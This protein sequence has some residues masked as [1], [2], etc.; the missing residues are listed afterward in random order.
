MTLSKYIKELQKLEAAGYGKYKVVYASDDEGNSFAEINHTPSIG[1][2]TK[3]C[4]FIPAQDFEDW[5]H[6]GGSNAICLN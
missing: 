2:F 3:D 1:A 6:K 4:D 5:E